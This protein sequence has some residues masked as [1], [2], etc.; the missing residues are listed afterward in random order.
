MDEEVGEMLVKLKFSDEETRKLFSL[1]SEVV[2]SGVWEA[3][4][5]GK[6]LTEVKINK[7]A[8]YKVL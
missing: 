5:V 7:E 6:L 2:K 8:M 4:A 1:D 3:W